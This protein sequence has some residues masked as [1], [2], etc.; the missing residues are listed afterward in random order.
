MPRVNSQ[1]HCRL[2]LC[3][4][5][6]AGRK[7]LEG[8]NSVLLDSELFPHLSRTR[9]GDAGPALKI[10]PDCGIKGFVPNCR[11]ANG[12]GGAEEKEDGTVYLSRKPRGQQQS[13][14]DQAAVLQEMGG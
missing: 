5:L 6:L 11:S 9:K 4:Q 13:R 1:E 12:A 3:G 2:C 7:P 8:S 10:W 14:L